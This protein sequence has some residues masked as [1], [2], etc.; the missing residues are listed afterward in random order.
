MC[1][2]ILQNELEELNW[3]PMSDR[4]NQYVLSITFKF[5]TDIGPNHLCGLLQWANESNRT[6]RTLRNNY[7]K[8]KLSFFKTTAGQNSLS[9]L[10]PSKWNNLL[11]PAK[12]LNNI[13]NFK[14]NF[15]KLYL[16]KL[17]N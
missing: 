2:N 14:H 5:A 8:L 12:K 13:N 16:T 17:A 1:S 11:E 6:R 10:V 7:Y 9:F 3:L 4:I 15:K